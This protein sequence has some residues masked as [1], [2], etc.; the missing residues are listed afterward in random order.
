M[1]LL[2]LLQSSTP[3]REVLATFGQLGQADRASLIGVQQALVGA[4]GPVQ[5]G[6]QLLLGGLLPGGACGGGEAVELRQE[7]VGVGK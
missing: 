4:C 6:A 5:P 7:L 1:A 3:L 2:L